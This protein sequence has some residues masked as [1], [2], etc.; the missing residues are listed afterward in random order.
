MLFLRTSWA[1]TKPKAG[2]KR[3]VHC[4]LAGCC[5]QEL[6]LSPACSADP[7]L[8]AFEV[9]G[10]QQPGALMLQSPQRSLAPV[11]SFHRSDLFV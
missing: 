1:L 4:R 6:C 3:E 2:K 5:K 10:V 8:A 7:G 9:P 11:L